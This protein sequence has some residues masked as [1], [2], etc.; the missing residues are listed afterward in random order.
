MKKCRREQLSRE[1]TGTAAKYDHAAAADPLDLANQRIQRRSVVKEQTQRVSGQA[2]ATAS[3]GFFDHHRAARRF[4]RF[5]EL[6]IRGQ[7]TQRPELTLSIGKAQRLK[8]PSQPC[9]KRART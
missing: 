5:A 2:G 6:F 3:S 9:G 8:Q 1:T 4:D 7:D